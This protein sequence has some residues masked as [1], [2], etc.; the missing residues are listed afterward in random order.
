MI[1]STL[2]DGDGRGNKAAVEDKALCVSDRGI[3]PQSLNGEVRIFRQYLTADGTDSGSNDMKV[4]GTSTAAIPFYVSAASDADRYI[5]T[6]SFLI[7]DANANLNQFGNITALSNGCNLYYEDTDLGDVTI[8]DALTSNFDFVRMCNGNPSFGNTTNVFKASNAFGNS[9][10][11]LPVLNIKEV[12]GLTWGI[13]L[14]KNSTK[15]IVLEV[16]DDA[17]GVDAF[18]CIAY[19]FDR[20][21]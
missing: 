15:R 3:P 20:I 2:V 21:R 6:L 19:G 8:D 1:K 13:K 5:C 17:T 18:N 12:F 4:N 10:G 14:E 11:Y 7:A 16:K 9:D